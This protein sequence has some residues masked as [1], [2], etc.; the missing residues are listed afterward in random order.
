MKKY[1]IL[2]SALTVTGCVNNGQKDIYT[3]QHNIDVVKLATESKTQKSLKNVFAIIDQFDEL[4]ELEQLHTKV[5]GTEWNFTTQ[6]YD[7]VA[8]T[9]A[10]ICGT[11]ISDDADFSLSVFVEI[12]G[13][14]FDRK[15]KQHELSPEYK[16]L[17]NLFFDKNMIDS[18][19]PKERAMLQKCIYT[20]Y[21]NN[22]YFGKHFC[23]L[24]FERSQECTDFRK[25][26]F[27]SKRNELCLFNYNDWLPD[28]IK[29]SKYENLL[30]LYGAYKSSLKECDSKIIKTNNFVCDKQPD[31]SQ[32][33]YEQEHKLT[34]A[35]KQQCYDEVEKKLNA[36]AKSGDL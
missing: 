19:T 28:D 36:L 18:I 32:K 26:Y 33:C 34:D 11:T 10:G 16:Q 4:P 3:N 13:Y 1:L 21:C 15:Y 25:E 6:K 23:G 9:S 5:N 17:S 29:I 24:G 35:E 2:I 8:N 22:T 20:R 14:Y 12:Y 31:G 30:K 27:D 7:Y